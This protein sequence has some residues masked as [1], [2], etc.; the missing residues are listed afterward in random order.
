MPRPKKKQPNRGDDRYEV[1]ITIGH[2]LDGSPIRKSFYSTVSMSDAREQ[3]QAYKTD[4]MIFTVTGIRRSELLGLTWENVNLPRKL[5]HI[6]RA[7]TPGIPA[8]ISIQFSG[9]WVIRRSR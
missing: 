7:V 8:R 5:I 3:A 2:R 1:K 4:Q 9:R 6:C